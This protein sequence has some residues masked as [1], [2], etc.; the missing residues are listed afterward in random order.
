MLLDDLNLIT[1]ALLGALIG[2][3]VAV[4]WVLFKAGFMTLVGLIGKIRRARYQTRLDKFRLEVAKEIAQGRPYA[5]N[6]RTLNWEF[7]GRRL[8][9][10]Q[11]VLEEVVLREAIRRMN[12]ETPD[13]SVGTSGRA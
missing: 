2:V 7:L 10:T 3:A 6:A 13:R 8:D 9:E 11:Y 1:T 5:L 4:A 12:G